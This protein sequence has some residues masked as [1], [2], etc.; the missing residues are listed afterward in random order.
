MTSQ[1]GDEAL[2]FSKQAHRVL[3]KFESTLHAKD[4]ICC[5][6]THIAT[7]AECVINLYDFWTQY[8]R[9]LFVASSYGDIDTLAGT[10]T[11]RARNFPAGADL[12][13]TL[14]SLSPSGRRRPLGQEPSWGIPREIN[15]ALNSIGAHNK[16]SV[17]LAV[18]SS[19][20]PSEEI[21]N[22]RNFFA[23][24]NQG[25]ATK[26]RL[27]LSAHSLPSLHNF[28]AAIQTSVRSG[29]ASMFEDWVHRLIAVAYAACQ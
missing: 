2:K 20:S 24:R 3:R 15:Q 9:R 17:S 4:G 19:N 28:D 25:T 11:P 10:H 6:Q 1:L 26:A 21:R 14:R 13:I 5:D 29:S 16:V 22:V 18:N 8:C 12:M 23:H 27:A 7:R